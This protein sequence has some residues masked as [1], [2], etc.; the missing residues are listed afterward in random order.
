MKRL[1]FA[2]LLCSAL[3]VVEFSVFV[4][5]TSAGTDI[6]V[7]LLDL[8]A[9]PPQNPLVP[10]PDRHPDTFYK[11]YDPPPDNAPIE[12]LMDY[13]EH[14][15]ANTANLSYKPVPSETV[16]SR[17]VSELRLHPERTASFVEI[18]PVT[19]ETRDFVKETYDLADALP[20]RVRIELRNWLLYN[21][22]HFIDDLSVIAGRVG[23]NGDYVSNRDQLLAFARVDF[24][25][26][27]PLID[28]LGQL[29]PEPPEIVDPENPTSG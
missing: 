11:N 29:Y 9:P 3:F 6:V 27:K 8:P 22:S 25:R 26:A 4:P 1:C 19:R 16:V 2:L 10:Q 12:D 13:W 14:Q 7:T 5:R 20:N 24:D 15:S 17:I 18:L 21:S 28:R 23:S